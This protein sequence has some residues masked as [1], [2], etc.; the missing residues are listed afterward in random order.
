MKLTAKQQRGLRRDIREMKRDYN[1]LLR[2][3]R[4]AR[5]LACRD[6]CIGKAG[7]MLDAIIILLGHAVA[8][9]RADIMRARKTLATSR[10]NLISMTGH[11]R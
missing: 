1:E 10:R 5:L 11:G 7:P 2:M 9:Q 4:S 6:S 8:G 3:Q